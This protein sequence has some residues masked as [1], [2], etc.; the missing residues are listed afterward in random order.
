MPISKGNLRATA[1]AAERPHSEMVMTNRVGASA[2]G[3]DER[4]LQGVAVISMLAVVGA[5]GHHR[6]G[7]PERY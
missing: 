1:K 7:F 2:N 3:H 4:V 6:A 5:A